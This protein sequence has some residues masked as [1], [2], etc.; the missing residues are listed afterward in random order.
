V[1]LQIQ[2]YLCFPDKSI[3]SDFL[4]LFL[5]TFK[6]R[7][8]SE[9]DKKTNILGGALTSTYTRA[10][11][12]FEN[13][14]SSQLS[15][16]ILSHFNLLKKMSKYIQMCVWGFLKFTTLKMNRSYI[17]MMLFKHY[18]ENIYLHCYSV[19]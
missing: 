18:L 5:T 1:F 2:F 14:I 7:E 16:F 13:S 19:A 10:T 12:S 4:R 11:S 9:S 8:I 6:L 3:L 15:N 17:Q